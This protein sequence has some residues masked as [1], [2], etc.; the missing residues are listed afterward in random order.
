M[1]VAFVQRCQ[2]SSIAARPLASNR[3]LVFEKVAPF[4]G[5]E[6]VTTSPHETDVKSGLML[7]IYAAEHLCGSHFVPRKWSRFRAQKVAPLFQKLALYWTPEDE[8]K[9]CRIRGHL[10]PE[11]EGFPSRAGE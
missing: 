4:S 6:I 10:V 11:T 7:C 8:P 2:T 5:L 3:A 9:V 1:A